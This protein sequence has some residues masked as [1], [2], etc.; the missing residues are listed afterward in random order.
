M[1]KIMMYYDANFIN[2]K[3][4]IRQRIIWAGRNGIFEDMIAEPSVNTN[5]KKKNYI[6]I[7]KTINK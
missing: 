5:T 7:R 6:R 1:T 3:I 2:T 4:T